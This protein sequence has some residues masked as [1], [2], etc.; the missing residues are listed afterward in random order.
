M[1]WT[2]VTGGQ[3]QLTM[4]LSM[5]D[6]G[7]NEKLYLPQS[8]YTTAVT[9]ALPLVN[10]RVAFLCDNCFLEWAF[11][12]QLGGTRD[13]A[14]VLDAYPVKGGFA[15]VGASP[16]ED[17]HTPN[18]ITDAVMYRLENS[19]GSWAQRWIHSIPDSEINQGALTDVY[20]PQTA[21]PPAV[22]PGTTTWITILSYYLYLIKTTTVMFRTVAGGSPPTM[23]TDT[24]AKCFPRKAGFHK[25]GKVFGVPLGRANP[26]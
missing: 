24:P 7:W 4:R 12:N 19:T 21:P 16:T 14:T 23:Q 18:S 17:T 26:R 3:F 1:A 6:L 25:V 15:G 10:M 9:A 22:V 5:D 13:G 11:V 8:D 2:N 20:V